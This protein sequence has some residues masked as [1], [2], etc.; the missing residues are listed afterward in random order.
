LPLADIV[1]MV[2][3]WNAPSKVTISCAPPLCFWAPLAGE[4][5]R[6]L[7]GLRAGVAEED[8]LETRVGDQHLGQAESRLVEV[9]R[10]RGDEAAGLGLERVDHHRGTVAERVDGPALD[11]VEIP[12]PGVIG[13]P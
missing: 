9:G 10:T 12:L 3:P 7:V 13:Q 1:A 2:R 11:E 6:A 4:L 8:A 5:D